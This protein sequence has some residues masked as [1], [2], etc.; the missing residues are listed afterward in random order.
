MEFDHLYMYTKK[1]IRNCPLA[2][3]ID[4]QQRFNDLLELSAEITRD[5]YRLNGG[6]T[7]LTTE[8]VVTTFYIVC[9]ELGLDEEFKEK[10]HG[11]N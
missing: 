7:R 6:C 3:D 4:E 9:D 8:D 10:I 1:F 5:F 11:N 2:I